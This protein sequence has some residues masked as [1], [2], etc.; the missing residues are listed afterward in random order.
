MGQSDEG[1]LWL[2][3]K[4]G[5]GDAF[6]AVFD[7]YGDRVYH[8]ARRLVATVADA[9]DVTAIAFFELW[10]RRRSVR[11]VEGSV[12]PWLLVTATN[13]SRNL[14]RGLR[15]YRALLA[16]LPRSGVEPGADELAL[17][18]VGAEQLRRDL[19]G[20]L[21]QLSPTDAAIVALTSF[22]HYTPAEAAAALGI[23]AGAARTRLHRARA[24]LADVLG[25][26]ESHEPFEMPKEDC[27]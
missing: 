23:S 7:L 21:A 19:R 20:A 18:A 2:S 11:V 3:A 27:Q 14:N 17:T 1:H 16:G 25:N 8:H 24:R 10:R 12:L 9:E 22:E 26:W 4:S 5:D 6:G 15:R 13:L